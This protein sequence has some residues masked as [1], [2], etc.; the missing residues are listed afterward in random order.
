MATSTGTTIFDPFFD[1]FQKGVDVA[2]S[3]L[4]KYTSFL[5]AKSA[6]LIKKK[7]EN[8]TEQ[9]QL[10]SAPSPFYLSGNIPTIALNVGAAA[11]VAL[12]IVFIWK[13]V[14]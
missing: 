13:A 5:E 6:L 9:T 8:R 14:K 11:A 12:A 2:G 3:G 1:I 10:P 4:E 7:Q